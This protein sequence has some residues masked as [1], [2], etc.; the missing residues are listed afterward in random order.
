MIWDLDCFFFLFSSI[1]F[2]HFS[3]IIFEQQLFCSTLRPQVLRCK[4]QV[5]SDDVQPIILTQT[6]E[7]AENQ[8]SI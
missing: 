6:L 4:L 7:A 2:H 3:S 8:S 5:I 1:I